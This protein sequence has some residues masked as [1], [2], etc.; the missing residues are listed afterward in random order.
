MPTY[1]YECQICGHV[2]EHFQSIKSEHLKKCPKCSK[3]KVKRLLGAG[4][5]ILFKG[6]GFYQTDYR[7]S[8]Y[9]KGVGA[10]KP[11]PVAD[12]TPAAADK[13]PAAAGKTPAAAGK[14][15]SHTAKG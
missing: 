5:G 13:T 1:D 4:S 12:K 14:P 9:T 3:N 10:D 6:S 7:S 11:A 8:S 15:A 2:F